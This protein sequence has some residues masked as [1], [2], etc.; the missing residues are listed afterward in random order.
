MAKK[1]KEDRLLSP[2]MHVARKY[3]IHKEPAYWAAFIF[4]LAAGSI[5]YSFSDIRPSDQLLAAP[6]LNTLF[7]FKLT[8]VLIFFVIL[9]V[10]LLIALV[11]KRLAARQYE[12]A[13]TK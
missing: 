6:E 3:Q 7:G 4:L 10:I 9:V 11:S 13:L 12:K 8:A 2:K 1:I 5:L